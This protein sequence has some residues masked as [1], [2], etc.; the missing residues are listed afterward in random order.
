VSTR[1]PSWG[2]C[3]DDWSWREASWPD[4]IRAALVVLAL[5]AVL[6]AA[7]FAGSGPVA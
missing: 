3:P 5:L 1:P 7:G 4:R 2:Y 6:V